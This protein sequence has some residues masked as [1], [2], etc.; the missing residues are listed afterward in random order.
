M[1]FKSQYTKLWGRKLNKV[2]LSWQVA[3]VRNI[4]CLSYLLPFR[5]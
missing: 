4:L 5:C 2:I 3:W 1:K